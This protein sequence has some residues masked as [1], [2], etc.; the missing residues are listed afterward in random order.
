[1]GREK[2]PGSDEVNIDPKDFIPRGTLTRTRNGKMLHGYT[3]ITLRDAQAWLVFLVTL[4]SLLGTM[5]GFGEWV[6]APRLEAKMRA[7]AE[8]LIA[9]IQREI[10]TL[11]R[12]VVEG[13]AQHILKVDAQ[14]DFDAMTKQ[15]DKV[16]AQVDFLVQNEIRKAR[17][18]GG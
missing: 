8:T 18:P 5:Y 3:S 15:I 9:P 1:M 7:T 10:T 6:I 16:A 12:E 4:C 14:K 17:R 13:D 2:L 11:R